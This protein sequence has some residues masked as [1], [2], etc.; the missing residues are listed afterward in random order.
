M[1]DKT[2]LV[3]E[4]ETIINLMASH[5]QKPEEA[6]IDKSFLMKMD[7]IRKSTYYQ[8]ISDLGSKIRG[9]TIINSQ[10]GPTGYLLNFSDNTWMLS[11]LSNG[12]QN[13]LLG[14]G[15]PTAFQLGFL[16]N[17]SYQDGKGPL[18]LNL[19][20]AQEVNDIGQAAQNTHGKTVRGISIGER[21]FGVCFPDGLELEGH[22]F[23]KDTLWTLRVFWEQW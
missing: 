10:G 6:P 17:L 2:R 12:Y 13:G 16:N 5:D 1:D 23:L 4:C 15:V 22:V 7:K 19:P 8:D 14:D 9:K 21:S 11:F 3:F 20:Y 18:E